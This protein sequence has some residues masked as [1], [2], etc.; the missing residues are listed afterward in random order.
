MKK[1]ITLFPGSFDPITKGHEDLVKRALLL[2]DEVVIGIGQNS[3]KKYMFTLEK[4]IKFIKETFKEF[5]QVKVVPYEGLTIE[6]C[7]QENIPFILRGLRSATDF[8]FERSIAQMNKAMH[9]E[10]ETIFLMTEPSLSAISS[11]IVRD[12][13]RGK[14]NVDAFVPDAISKMIK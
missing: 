2:F 5:P 13:I 8:D 12:I 9:N 11:T 10:S 1:T 7:K 6:F 14:G 4:R 3:N